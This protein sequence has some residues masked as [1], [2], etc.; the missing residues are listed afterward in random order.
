MAPHT[1]AVM[2]L[3]PPQ[4]ATLCGIRR[5]PRCLLS[6]TA[7]PVQDEEVRNADSALLAMKAAPP[8]PGLADLFARCA[9]GAGGEACSVS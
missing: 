1:S 7:G 8:E 9:L 6:L 4:D 3:T 2:T 5:A